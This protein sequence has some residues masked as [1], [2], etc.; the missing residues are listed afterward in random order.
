[1]AEEAK[2]LGNEAFARGDHETAIKHF[3]EAIGLDPSNHVLYSNRSAAHA[4]RGNYQAALDDAEKTVALKPDWPKGYGR[5]GAALQFLGR[6]EQAEGA[7]K[8]GLELD[9]ANE[10][11]KGGL[12]Q[13][14]AAMEEES[15]AQQR[16]NPENLFVGNYQEKLRAHPLTAPHMSDAGFV[17][18]LEEIAANPRGIESKIKDQR[19]MMALAVLMGIPI[20][21]E[22]SPAPAPAPAAPAAAQKTPPQAS[23]KPEPMQDESMPANQREAEKEKEAGNED[24]K[25]KRFES[26][27]AHYARAVE[28]Y[29]DQDAT[30]RSNLA[31]AYLE[32]GETDKCIAE[33]QEALEDCKKQHNYKLVPRLLTRQGNAYAKQEK[34]DEAVV[35]YQK[36]LTENRNADTLAR[37]QKAEKARKEAREKAYLN[38]ELSI[39]EK[40]RGNELF[41]AQQY[42][43]A[44]AAYSEAIKR[45]PLDHVPYSNRSACYMKLAEFPSA[46]KDAEKCLEIAPNF[47]K[48]W[49]RKAACHFFMK[50]YHKAIAAYDAGLKIEPGNQECLEGIAKIEQTVASQQDKDKPDEEQIKRSM[51]DPEIRSILTDPIM[52]QVIQDLSTDPARSQHHLRNPDVMAKIQKLVAAGVLRMK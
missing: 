25:A 40:N 14:Q 26:A 36:S 45:N 33:C 4:A 39:A 16:F 12:E 47:V 13:C 15:A 50:E 3:S 21:K 9:P 18:L 41:K 8:K 49:S 17:A 7:Y 27:V 38:P 24:Y 6:L 29:G 43:E 42:P 19:V 32:M 5:K 52:Q 34:W 51:A 46:L 30:Y 31:A 48:G 11:L 37:L 35:C 28:L 23:P 1:M 22:D 2:K 20:T 44:I 10:Q